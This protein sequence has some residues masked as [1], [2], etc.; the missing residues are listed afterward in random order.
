MKKSF[1]LL[2]ICLISFAQ[3]LKAQH[4]S[5][6]YLDSVKDFFKEWVENQPDFVYVIIDNTSEPS[7]INFCLHLIDEHASFK[8]PCIVYKRKSENRYSDKIDSITM[9]E[10]ETEFTLQKL[11]ESKTNKWSKETF[12]M[13]EIIDS[14]KFDSIIYSSR[15]HPNPG[16]WSI[17]L[18]YFFRNG[19]LAIVYYHYYCGGDCGYA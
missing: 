19:T 17:S 18:P 10:I 14:S 5:K 16:I 13:A 1:L 15:N 7:E 9:T 12:P 4:L 11:Q 3:Q 6:E 8:N 2:A